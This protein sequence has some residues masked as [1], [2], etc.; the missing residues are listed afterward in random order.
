MWFTGIGGGNRV[1]FEVSNRLS[2]RGHNVKLVALK[3]QNWFPLKPELIV[4]DKHQN[5]PDAIP[6]SDVLFATFCWT[7]YVVDK[8]K[9]RKGTPAY[10]CQHYEPY[11]FNDA[12]QQKA[13]AKTYELPINLIA[14]SPW[15]Q[16]TLKEKHG[17]DSHLVVPG[18]DAETFHAHQT[19]DHE[20]FRI[21]YFSTLD[22]F[23]GL[24]DTT[25]PALRNVWQHNKNIEF[26]TYGADA[27]YPIPIVN[28]GRLSDDELAHLYSSCDLYVCGSWYESS[29]L[30]HLEAMACGCPVVSTPIG[31]E[32]YG[33]A[34]MRVPAHA[35]E[36]LAQKILTYIDNDIDKPEMAETVKQ[37][38]WDKTVDSV[39]E[40]MRDL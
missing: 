26:H 11:V 34:I 18:V 35:P 21:C 22:Q 38:T 13:I 19:E 32:H 36:F 39:E 14:N 28:H 2:E 25:L 3:P 10:Y 5:L 27:P 24:Y 1:I 37:F 16:Q 33:D 12:E 7:A 30:P 23:K 9:D 15:L 4:C 8:V 40:F 29:P 6:E 20:K 31:V 17:R